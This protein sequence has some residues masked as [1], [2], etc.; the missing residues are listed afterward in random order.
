MRDAQRDFLF[1]TD[2][3][4]I[5]SIVL[6]PLGDRSE[7]GFLAIGSRNAD[8]FHPGVSIDFLARLGQLVASALAT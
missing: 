6:I 5:G 8:H 3:F 7:L 4:E 2:N 1:G